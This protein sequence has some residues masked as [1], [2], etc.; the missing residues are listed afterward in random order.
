MKEENGKTFRLFLIFTGGLVTFTLLSFIGMHIYKPF[1]EQG[2]PA[3]ELIT[4]VMILIC[5]VY[6]GITEKLT[7]E[8][9]A[10]LLGAVLGYV[11]GKQ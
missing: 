7:S 10:S 3:L 5:I 8:T 2:Q 4:T 6:L 9:I 1:T 11:L